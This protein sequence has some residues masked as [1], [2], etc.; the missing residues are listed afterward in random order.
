MFTDIII[1]LF[2]DNTNKLKWYYYFT[3]SGVSDF[4]NVFFLKIFS[5]ILFNKTFAQTNSV[6]NIPNPAGITSIEGPGKNIITIPIK[7]TVEPAMAINILF[8]LFIVILSFSPS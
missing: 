4:M 8:K 1:I 2:L 7:R 3:S 6:A 5:F